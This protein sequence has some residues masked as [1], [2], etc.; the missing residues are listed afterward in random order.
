MQASKRCRSHQSHHE[1]FHSTYQW[2]LTLKV[3]FYYYPLSLLLP[4][5]SSSVLNIL[6]EGSGHHWAQPLDSEAVSTFLF[7]QYSIHEPQND[8]AFAL[9]FGR[10]EMMSVV[11]SLLHFLHTSF[12]SFPQP[13]CHCHL[14]RFMHVTNTLLIL[15]LKINSIIVIIIKNVF[16]LKNSSLWIWKT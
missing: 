4:P 10:F 15:I 2:Q 14:L 12:H 1:K 16:F 7:N 13:H 11:Q 9:F 3:K 8:N 6:S 5:A